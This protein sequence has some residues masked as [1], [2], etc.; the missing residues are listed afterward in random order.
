M[1]KK[2]LKPTVDVLHPRYCTGPK[3]LQVTTSLPSR[4]R[5]LLAPRKRYV[6]Q[7]RRRR[8]LVYCRDQNQGNHSEIKFLLVER[9]IY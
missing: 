1:S 6:A 2:N 4:V 7:K 9:N 8:H 3:C 5:F